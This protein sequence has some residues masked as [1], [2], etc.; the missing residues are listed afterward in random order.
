MQSEAVIDSARAIMA[1][2]HSYTTA[3]L[4][5]A[6]VLEAV[7]IA[8]LLWHRGWG[9]I[10]T[11]PL[12]NIRLANGIA[13]ASMFILS[14]MAVGYA[15]GTYPPVEVILALGSFI[16]LMC[17]LDVTQ[18][19]IKRWTTDPNVTSNQNVQAGITPGAPTSPPAPPAAPAPDI[20]PAVDPAPIA[21]A[22]ITPPPLASRAKASLPPHKYEPGN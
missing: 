22:V 1:L 2:H 17:G 12:T 5:V 21:P 7:V 16:L 11:A 6:L 15:T 18:F 19:G 10:A 9:W 20:P 4:I 3:G 13:M 14:V 8:L